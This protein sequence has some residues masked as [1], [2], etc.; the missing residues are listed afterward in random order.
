LVHQEQ[1][2]PA[3]YLHAVQEWRKGITELAPRIDRTLTASQRR[4]ALDKLQR[5]ITQVRD[6]YR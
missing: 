5:L 2:A 4:Y 3:W 1:S 6:L